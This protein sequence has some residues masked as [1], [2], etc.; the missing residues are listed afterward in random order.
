MAF[1][2]ALASA[3]GLKSLAAHTVPLSCEKR[4]G[5]Q[6]VC[7][8]PWRTRSREEHAERQGPSRLSPKP[9]SLGEEVQ[10]TKPLRAERAESQ[11]WRQLSAGE[12][13]GSS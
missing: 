4:D 6:H 2:R 3:S 12:G 1:R 5:I 9:S 8:G 10:H 11:A 7:G 13:R